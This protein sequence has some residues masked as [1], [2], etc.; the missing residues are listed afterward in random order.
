MPQISNPIKSRPVT[1]ELVWQKMTPTL[2]DEVISFWES[3]Q[4]L[5]S[6]STLQERVRQV[7]FLVRDTATLKIVGVS[8]AGLVNFK[9]LNSNIFYLYRSIILPAYRYPGL[10]DKLTIE[11]RDY[12]ENFNRTVS[13]NKAIGILVFV[14]NLK[15]QQFRREAIWR[16]SRLAYIGT[17]KSGRHIRVYYFK[18]ARI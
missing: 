18:G 10:A 6:D 12:L 13:E 1:L 4:M 5:R 9:Q 15:F 3:N 2:I 7:V 11:T 16:A 17:D 8:T 14:E